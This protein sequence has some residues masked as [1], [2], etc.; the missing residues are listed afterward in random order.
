MEQRPASFGQTPKERLKT[1]KTQA[2]GSPSAP[3]QPPAVDEDDVPLSRLPP[4]APVAPPAF[5]PLKKRKPEAPKVEPPK[6][7][8]SGGSESTT[9][10]TNAAPA[11]AAQAAAPATAAQAAA[12]KPSAERGPSQKKPPRE[13]GTGR[14][15]D[16]LEGFVESSTLLSDKHVRPE[17]REAPP[18]RQR[19]PQLAA[20]ARPTS[21]APPEQKLSSKAVP[22]A[23]S[24]PSQR[25]KQPETARPAAGPATTTA[26]ASTTTTT[27]TNTT[28]DQ[29][30]ACSAPFSRPDRPRSVDPASSHP[31]KPDP[32]PEPQPEPGQPE[33]AA[34]TSAVTG[35]TGP[36]SRST[37]PVSRSTSPAQPESAPPAASTSKQAAGRA[38][39]ASPSTSTSTGQQEPVSRSL[40]NQQ[41]GERT[42]APAAAP[43]AVAAAASRPQEGAPAA[44]GRPRPS[45][46]AMPAM[47]PGAEALPTEY[48]GVR[49]ILSTKSPT[50]YRGVTRR[51]NRFNIRV[52]HAIRV[53]G[54]PL[55]APQLTSLT[56][57]GWCLACSGPRLRLLAAPGT[58]G[59]LLDRSGPRRRLRPGGEGWPSSPTQWPSPRR[60]LREYRWFDT[61]VAAAACYARARSGEAGQPGGAGEHAA[62]GWEDGVEAE[63]AEAAEAEA[64]AEEAAPTDLATEH[65]GVALP[66]PHPHPHPHPQPASD[67]E[68]GPRPLPRP[69][70]QPCP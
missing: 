46:A 21:E 41:E 4:P 61:A 7:L 48:D 14:V 28:T 53:G 5:L 30:R 29:A 45:T 57:A 54:G 15:H 63:E 12:P 2:C 40:D 58:R 3:P 22:P 31:V 25:E 10:A 42:H 67:L 50:G 66:H 13:N 27:T 1:Q 17:T 69:C 64:E 55:A 59:E 36:V 56:C 24:A 6:P 33:P 38:A 19:S 18:K 20:Q 49:L 70:P 60:P 16:P 65:E 35:Y 34:S 43:A 23:G 8:M 37:S 11:T 47:Q 68:P 39:A 62:E 52:G 51:G 32:K 44:A 9:E 26:T